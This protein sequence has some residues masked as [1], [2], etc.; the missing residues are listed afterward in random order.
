MSWASC[1]SDSRRVDWAWAEEGL[2]TEIRRSDARAMIVC[3][4]LKFM[5]GLFH[6]GGWVRNQGRCKSKTKRRGA[7]DSEERG[8]VGDVVT[9]CGDV[10]SPTGRCR[11][12]VRRRMR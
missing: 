6:G 5:R 12:F 2:A 3:E 4:I 9:W 11:R 10:K 8:G 1:F 7:E